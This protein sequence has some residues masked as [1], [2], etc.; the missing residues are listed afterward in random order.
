MFAYRHPV[1]PA[2]LIE[3]IIFL[4]LNYFHSFV[5]SQLAVVL[6]VS[7]WILYAVSLICASVPPPVSHS[8]EC[9]RYRESQ[10]VKNDSFHFVFPGYSSWVCKQSDTTEHT[11]TP[12]HTPHFAWITLSLVGN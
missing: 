6:W 1:C 12:P 11:H 9:C 4:P 2:P 10:S 8:L 7:L 5:K 3:K